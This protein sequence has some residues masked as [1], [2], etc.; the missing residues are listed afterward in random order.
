MTKRDTTIQVGGVELS[1]DFV[2][3]KNKG[4]D[5]KCELPAIAQERKSK[6]NTIHLFSPFALFLRGASM[7]F[8]LCMY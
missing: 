1:R 6:L 8:C 4:V 2:Y 7:S 5:L 3:K